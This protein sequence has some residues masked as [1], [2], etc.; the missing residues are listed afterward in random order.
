MSA[1]LT[2]AMGLQ[3]EVTLSKHYSFILLPSLSRTIRA[4]PDTYSLN[5]VSAE[6]ASVLIAAGAL[7]VLNAT[8]RHLDPPEIRVSF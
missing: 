6:V 8:R 5:K 2:T 3:V 7:N 1:S 4:T